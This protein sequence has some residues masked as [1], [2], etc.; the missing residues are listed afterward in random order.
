[1]TPDLCQRITDYLTCGGLFNPESAL[2]ERV[3]DLLIE[4]RTELE[5]RAVAEKAPAPLR[6]QLE[7]LVARAEWHREQD[8]ALAGVAQEVPKGGDTLPERFDRLHKQEWGS[9]EPLNSTS[10]AS[11]LN[12][13][14]IVDE[15][16]DLFPQDPIFDENVLTSIIR[17]K[18]LAL[19]GRFTLAAPQV[20]EETVRLEEARWWRGRTDGIHMGDCR[21][22][23]CDH[24]H[25]LERAALAPRE[26]EEGKS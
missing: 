6:K 8:A 26:T 24:I 14:E 5:A 19:K 12:A 11:P 1:M 7:D 3:R 18:L 15:C 21:C 23:L 20:R 2:H 13:D 25:E 22:N 4:C 10:A 9:T 16:L 17:K